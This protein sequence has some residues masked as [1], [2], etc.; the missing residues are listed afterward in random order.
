VASL[1][2]IVDYWAGGLTVSPD[3][4]AVI[5]SQRAYRTSQV[6]LIQNFR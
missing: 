6:M 2:G 5:Y 3:R 4:R 1:G